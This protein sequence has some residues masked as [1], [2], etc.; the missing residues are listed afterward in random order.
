VFAGVMSAALLGEAPRWYHAASFALIAAGIVV[1]S[2]APRK[3]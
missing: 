3:A 1:S 2:L